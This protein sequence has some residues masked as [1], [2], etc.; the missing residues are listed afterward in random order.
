MELDGG[1]AG[2]QGDLTDVTRSNFA[3]ALPR[4]RGAISAAAF[5][6]LDLE[7]TGL[8]LPHQPRDEF[9]DEPQDR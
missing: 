2:S 9:L 5:V 4:I 8:T 3:A 6:A 1:A 7:M